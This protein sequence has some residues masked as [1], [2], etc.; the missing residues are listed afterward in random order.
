MNLIRQE[1]DTFKTVVIETLN[2]INQRILEY[3]L[4]YFVHHDIVQDNTHYYFE[5]LL[6]SV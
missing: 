4:S 5:S 3:I 6:K 1:I 2:V